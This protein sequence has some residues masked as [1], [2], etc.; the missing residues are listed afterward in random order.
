VIYGLASAKQAGIPVPQD[1]LNRGYA[2][3]EKTLTEDLVRR[4]DWHE[5]V[6]SLYALSL[7]RTSANKDVAKAVDSLFAERANLTVYG[8]ALL[9]LALVNYKDKRAAVLSRN[10]RDAFEIDAERGTAT[11]TRP[12]GIPWYWWRWYCDDEESVAWSLRA[13][14]AVKDDQSGADELPP[15]LVRYLVDKKRGSIWRSTKSTALII[16]ALAEYLKA[17]GELTARSKVTV[18]LKGENGADKLTRTFE[19][20]PEN[21]LL[22]DREFLVPTAL[23]GAGKQTVTITREG[24]GKVYWNAA[25]QFVTQEEKIA[26][27]G[28][29]LQVTR[30]YFRLLE[31]GADVGKRVE[32]KDGEPL[33]SGDKIEVEMTIT[34][35]NELDYVLFE[36]MKPAGYEPL[37]QLSGFTFGEGIYAHSELRDTKVAFFVTHLPRG[38]NALRYR[39]RAETPGVF[40]ALPTNGY[41]MYAPDVRALSNSETLTVRDAEAKKTGVD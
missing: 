11:P 15:L 37:E 7:S 34:A 25:C 16:H 17:S 21:A 19:F 39:L 29:T 20:T 2:Y 31:T 4:K 18:A 8:K 40:H 14:T 1:A 32:L 33:R 23:L 12:A 10:L 6:W 28:D 5:A 24:T 38:V 9:T 22:L 3:L 35:K 30:R 41:A 27:A 26:G 36:D 13:F